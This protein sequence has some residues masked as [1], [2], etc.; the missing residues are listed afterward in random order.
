MDDQYRKLQEK[1]DAIARNEPLPPV[2]EEEGP[3]GIKD[4][5]YE[6]IMGF[7][8]QWT[9]A[10]QPDDYMGD[11][12]AYVKKTIPNS[13]DWKYAASLIKNGVESYQNREYGT[14]SLMGLRNNTESVEEAVAGGGVDDLYEINRMV[15]LAGLEEA[16]DDTNKELARTARIL[17]A[18]IREAMLKSQSAE[19]VSTE[20]F[21]ELQ[22][23]ARILQ[24]RISGVTSGPDYDSNGDAVAEGASKSK[25]IDDAESMSMEEFVE[26]YS[27][28]GM[29]DEEAKQAYKEI[30]GEAVTE[31]VEEA[32]AGGGVDDLYE[33]L[34]MGIS[35]EG[36]FDEW[37]AYSS[38]DDIGEFVDHFKQMHSINMDEGSNKYS[39]DEFRKYWK[40]HP[41]IEAGK[42]IT[43]KANADD[44]QQ[45]ASNNPYLK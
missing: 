20:E 4:S 26:E 35:K 18:R 29:S 7:V 34:D 9:E 12:I 32:V 43:Q 2:N 5:N 37:V 36:L 15:E 44:S 16:P 1:I 23:L 22:K 11:L 19:E 3:Y 33:L 41:A 25:M 17:Q 8:N 6:I 21:K 27:A 24:A 31:S 14:S 45:V 42:Q 30:M 13:N 38:S 39:N 10:G 40:E 28:Q